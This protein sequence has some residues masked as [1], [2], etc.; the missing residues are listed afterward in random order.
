MD[1]A[2]SPSVLQ[3]RLKNPKQLTSEEKIVYKELRRQ[4][5]ISAEQKRRGSIKQGFDHL[6]SLLINP[7]TYPTGKVSKTAIL[8]K[9]IEYIED[10]HQKRL[11]REKKMEVLRKEIAQLNKDICDFQQTLPASGAPIT[12]QR[13]EEN[14]QRFREYV[15]RKT[16]QNY[17][18]WIFSIILQQLFESY[19]ATV[20]TGNTDELCRTVLAWFEQK[21]SLPSLRPVVFSSLKELSVKTSILSDPS[22]VPQQ[23]K[24]YA[25]QRMEEQ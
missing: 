6:Q 20:S 8:E 14:R 21:C 15:Q 4:S 7:A 25:R 10:S 17:K 5:H 12:R 22:Q 23:L 24:E 13:F 16:L 2:Y 19:N 9:C 1:V 3:R 11:N 18:F